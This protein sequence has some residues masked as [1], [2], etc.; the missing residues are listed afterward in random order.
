MTPAQSIMRRATEAVMDKP[1]PVGVN[2]GTFASMSLDEARQCAADLA[3]QLAIM[4]RA[5]KMAA[6]QISRGYGQIGQSTEGREPKP[7]HREVE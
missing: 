7:Q 4:H 3:L 1:A 2:G 6:P 5:W